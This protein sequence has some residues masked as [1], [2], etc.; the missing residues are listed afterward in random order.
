MS[1]TTFVEDRVVE[2]FSFGE[3][4]TARLAVCDA[5]NLEM[6]ARVALGPIDCTNPLALSK[7]K[8]Y[9]RLNECND[10]RALNFTI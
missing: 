2:T 1:V 4:F 7:K 9:I 10:I 3:V 8:R 5:L 6:V